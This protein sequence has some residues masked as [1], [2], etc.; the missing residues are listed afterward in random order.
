MSRKS[1]SKVDK[2]RRP[3]PK[4]GPKG[5]PVGK[6]R[7]PKP[8]VGNKGQPKPKVIHCRPPNPSMFDGEEYFL[9]EAKPKAAEGTGK[10]FACW[11]PSGMY[12]V[13]ECRSY[14]TR[15]IYPKF[16][17]DDTIVVYELSEKMRGNA[18]PNKNPIEAL[19][20]DTLLYFVKT[21]TARSAGATKIG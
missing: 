10:T 17:K 8:K 19:G 9:G 16:R 11:I 4:V 1:Q 12:Q 3:K 5:Q 14:G 18:A 21:T 13:V 6:K 2:K 7:R 20:K 15:N